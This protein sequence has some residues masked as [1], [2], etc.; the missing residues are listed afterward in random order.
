MHIMTMAPFNS[1]HDVKQIRI[2]FL[3]CHMAAMSHIF[4]P[5]HS[6]PLGTVYHP[7]SVK[8]IASWELLLWMC[9]PLVLLSAHVN[10]QQCLVVNGEELLLS[11]YEELC[12]IHIRL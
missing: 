1:L 4:Y 3:L 7:P 10:V 2:Q 9:T 8:T 5:H 11:M 12:H 6:I